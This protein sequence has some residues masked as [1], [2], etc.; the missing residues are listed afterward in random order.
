MAASSSFIIYK[1]T[2]LSRFP[3][4]ISSFNRVNCMKLLISRFTLYFGG[5]DGFPGDFVTSFQ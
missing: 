3:S 5:T 2:F 1:E 4:Q